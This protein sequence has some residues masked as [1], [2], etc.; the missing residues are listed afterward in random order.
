MELYR[1]PYRR[2]FPDD[3]KTPNNK[4]PKNYCFENKKKEIPKTKKNN[5]KRSHIAPLQDP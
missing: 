2:W 4:A 5:K 1:R 3:N